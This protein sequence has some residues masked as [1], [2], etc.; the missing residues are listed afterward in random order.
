[1][2]DYLGRPL[3]V[4]ARGLLDAAAAEKQVAESY[5]VMVTRF[6]HN[7]LLGLG[8]KIEPQGGLYLGE[9]KPTEPAPFVDDGVALISICHPPGSILYDELEA[10]AQEMEA[11]EMM[12][13]VRD[14]ARGS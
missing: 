14:I 3:P 2:K 7:T 6:D 12:T 10:E 8:W 13:A 11:D 5:R 9:S 4:D 1:M